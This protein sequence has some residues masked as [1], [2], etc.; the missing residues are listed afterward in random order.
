MPY[1]YPWTLP[2]LRISLACRLL[3]CPAGVSL[4]LVTVLAG[5]ASP[6][7]DLSVLA[8]VDY[9]AFD[10]RVTVGAIHGMSHE[11]SRFSIGQTRAFGDAE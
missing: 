9:I 11:F 8:T 7:D 2:A 5:F 6:A 10:E 1:L 3:G 4:S